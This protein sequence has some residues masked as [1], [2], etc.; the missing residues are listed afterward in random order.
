MDV[1]SCGPTN[2]RRVV[3]YNMCCIEAAP[4]TVAP[5]ANSLFSLRASIYYRHIH[6]IQ[7]TNT[8]IN[9][10]INML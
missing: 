7:N 2:D 1:Y 5:E 3:S 8:Y 6:I 10:F 9:T 4:A